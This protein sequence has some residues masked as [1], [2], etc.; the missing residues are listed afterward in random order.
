ML[1][2]KTLTLEFNI[3]DGDLSYCDHLEHVS[4]YPNRRHYNR[5]NE[6]LPKRE[7]RYS[8]FGD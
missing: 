7:R 8:T 3:E 4:F 6:D 2:L 1:N 5:K